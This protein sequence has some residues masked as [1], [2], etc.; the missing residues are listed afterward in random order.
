M[1]I[2][3][4]TSISKFGK[5][6]DVAALH[7]PGV[8]GEFHALTSS[9]TSILF[10]TDTVTILFGGHSKCQWGR[11]VKAIMMCQCSTKT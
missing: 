1:D 3:V 4:L 8:S 5:V 10:D 9:S 7:D 11:Q 6:P 2:E